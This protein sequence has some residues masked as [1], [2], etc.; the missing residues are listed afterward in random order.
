[1]KK[2]YIIES[3]S[4]FGIIDEFENFCYVPELDDEYD[5]PLKNKKRKSKNYFSNSDEENNL[6]SDDNSKSRNLKNEKNHLFLHIKLYE[7]ICTINVIL[8][9]LL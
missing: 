8:E 7:K 3:G 2:D 5:N 1:M 4:F 9:I 6:N